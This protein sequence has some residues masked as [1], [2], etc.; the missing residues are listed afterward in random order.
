M[1]KNFSKDGI[2]KL[3]KIGLKEIS[4]KTFIN[5]ENLEYLLNR[6]FEKLHKTQALGFIQILEREFDVDLKGLKNDYIYFKKYGRLRSPNETKVSK[7]N[8]VDIKKPPKNLKKPKTPKR[9]KMQDAPIRSKKS[10]L[11]KYA[12]FII[13]S[14]ISLLGFFLLKSA[15]DDKTI[16]IQDLNNSEKSVQVKDRKTE[17]ENSLV[18]KESEEKSIE[19]STKSN[20]TDE[21]IDLNAMVNKM[22]KDINESETKDTKEDADI[23]LKDDKKDSSSKNSDATKT[24]SDITKLSSTL[25]EIEGVK[26]DTKKSNNSLEKQEKADSS[27]KQEESSPKKITKQTKAKKSEKKSVVKNLY[28]TPIQKAWVGIIYIDDLSKKDYLIRANRKLKLDK[29]RDQIILVGHNKFK[30]FHNNKEKPFG[31]KKMV[32][33]LYQNGNLREINKQEYLDLSAGVHW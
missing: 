9:K 11:V 33:F 19:T 3:K 27:K 15:F 2:E 25:Q 1:D 18:S 21:D 7:E 14:I 8:Q 22:L 12:P 20:T 17:I 16:E 23:V 6:N 24:K 26:S 13:L 5:K 29:T 31:S 10:P 4:N 28:I 30:I 32:R